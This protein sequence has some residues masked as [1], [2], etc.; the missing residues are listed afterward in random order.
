MKKSHNMHR[1][2]PLDELKF[3][4]LN[5]ELLKLLIDDIDE[6]QLYC[7]RID[8]P[9]RYGR[10][11]DPTSAEGMREIID[12]GC[13]YMLR[14]DTYFTEHYDK[15]DMIWKGNNCSCNGL[16][17]HSYA[18]DNSHGQYPYNICPE[19]DGVDSDYY[20][21]EA[22]APC[23]FSTG[24]CYACLSETYANFW[25]INHN[26]FKHSCGFESF[27]DRLENA[28]PHFIHC[29]CNGSWNKI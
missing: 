22:V 1:I 17:S 25:N 10:N 16:S 3:V 18:R 19:L 5:D 21:H 2:I 23:F 15:H 8:K 20:G 9:Y 27:G 24:K 4:S 28:I 14:D 6:L 12:N 26:I 13:K 29:G 11:E 7:H